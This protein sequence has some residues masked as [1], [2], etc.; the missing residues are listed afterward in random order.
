MVDFGRQCLAKGSWDGAI[1]MI[2]V[3]AHMEA[4]HYSANGWQDKI[5][6]AYF[7][8]NDAAWDDIKAVYTAFF[9]RAPRNDCQK[10]Q[11]AKLAGLCGHWDEAHRMF[12][13]TG[14]AFDSRVFDTATERDKFAA[15]AAGR[16]TTAPTSNP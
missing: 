16:A 7:Q 13:E 12:L 14:K 5:D 15:E 11:Y 6:P 1:P 4:A 10:L 9:R 3:E 8:G 2:L